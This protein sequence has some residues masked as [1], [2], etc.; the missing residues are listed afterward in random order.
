VT[1]RTRGR[2][3]TSRGTGATRWV[4]MLAVTGGGSAGSVGGSTVA[5]G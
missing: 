2:R 1:L 5:V 4:V 3:P